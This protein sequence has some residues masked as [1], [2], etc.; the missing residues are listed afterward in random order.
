MQVLRIY[1]A[2]VGLYTSYSYEENSKDDVSER[3]T[4]E[5][6]K[7]SGFNFQLSALHRPLGIMI[8]RELCSKSLWSQTLDNLNH[9]VFA[10]YAI[11]GQFTR[12]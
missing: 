12:S 8:H 11:S 6:S 9:D 3:L 10:F 7:S 1:K 2:C 4:G 5:T